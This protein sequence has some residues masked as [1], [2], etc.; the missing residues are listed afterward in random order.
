[1]GAHAYGIARQSEKQ[2][3]APVRLPAGPTPAKG[4][5]PAV[6]IGLA[7]VLA[8]AYVALVTLGLL[9][10]DYSHVDQTRARISR[11]AEGVVNPVYDT[12]LRVPASWTIK[13]DTPNYI[14]LAV[15]SDRACSLTLQPIAWS[16]L[17]GLSSFKGQLAD[18][19]SKAKDLTG[20]VLDEQPAVLAVRFNDHPT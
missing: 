11:E 5:P 8:M 12:I 20:E 1:M 17:V 7:V 15:R 9:L 16:P 4:L 2:I 14:L 18:Q 13:N 10:P 6:P 3:L 19:F